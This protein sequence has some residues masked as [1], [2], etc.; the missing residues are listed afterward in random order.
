MSQMLNFAKST[1]GNKEHTTQ[2]QEPAEEIKETPETN[3]SYDPDTTDNPYEEPVPDDNVG[4]KIPYRPIIIALSILV[5]TSIAGLVAYHLH[6]SN[7]MAEKDK[8]IEK[9]ETKITEQDTEISEQ[10]ALIEKA[11]QT[12]NETIESVSKSNKKAA[13]ENQELEK[14]VKQY[15]DDLAENDTSEMESKMEELEAQASE[16]K[17]KIEELT[18]QLES[19][20]STIDKAKEDGVIND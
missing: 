20:K 15:A 10:Q 5:A 14:R 13:K 18:T 17:A 1:S 12:V 9:L 8:K 16:Q 4:K 19:Q 2:R 7:A 6:T 11:E 3:T